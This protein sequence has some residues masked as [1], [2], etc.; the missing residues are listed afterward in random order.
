MVVPVFVFGVFLSV[1]AVLC[2]LPLLLL[3]MA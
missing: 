3:G 1:A 2:L